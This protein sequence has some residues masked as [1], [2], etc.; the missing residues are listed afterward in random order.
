ME[1]MSLLKLEK[2]PKKK[3]EKGKVLKGR[4]GI[5]FSIISSQDSTEKTNK[6][7]VT[8]CKSMI[9]DFENE[10]RNKRTIN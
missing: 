5:I 1:Q 7:I 10:I 6:E 8:N 2:K 4:K 9:S 3:E